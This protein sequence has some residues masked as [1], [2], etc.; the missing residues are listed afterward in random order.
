M[1]ARSE[2]LPVVSGR[3]MPAGEWQEAPPIAFLLIALL[4]TALI[5]RFGHGPVTL[6]DSLAVYWVWADQFTAELAKGNLYPRWLPASNAGLGSPVFYYYPP[7]AYYV[8][9][10]F[11]LAGLTTYASLI[12]TFW[13][14]F[15]GSGMACWAW[16]RGQ[17][18]HPLLGAAF[19]MAA[20]YHLFNYVDRGAL[21]E[22][23]AT[24]LIPV[25]AIGLRRIAGGRG[26]LVMTAMTYGAMIGTHL[27]L[28]LLAGVFLVAPYALVHR[29]R[30][31]QFA[32]AILLGTAAAAIS[33]VPSLALNSYHDVGQ[34]YR[35][36]NL[37]TGYWSLLSG[38]WS[39]PTFAMI[40]AIVGA[41]VAASLVAGARRD[42]W[43]LQAIVVAFLVTGLVP[44]VWSLP[45][46]EK[47]QFPYRALSI[48][49]FGLATALARSPAILRASA[50]PLIASAAILPG[51]YNV[52][53]DLGRLR[54]MHPDV[55]EYLPKG[56]LR[57]NQ[58][59][60]MLSDV[61]ATRIPAPRIHGMVVESR[62]Y[63]PAWSC[64]TVEPRTQLL[65]H[66]AGCNPHITSTTAEKFGAAVSLL[67]ALALSMLASGR[68]FA[69]LSKPSVRL[70]D[71]LLG[72][73]HHPEGEPAIEHCAS[74]CARGAS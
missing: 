49:E 10:F 18:Q 69:R 72:Q 43:S 39:D 50:I 20:P 30:F 61:L 14:A 60:A 53:K 57:P 15:A 59:T 47:V 56:V 1:D 11:G 42:R 32:T 27:P 28:A 70:R 34:L 55:Y 16:L 29:H 71:A 45:L 73:A 23:L 51:F 19:F 67:A 58:T 46:L 74:D 52:P 66:E 17:S 36:P 12:A 7:L 2:A 31:P 26:G 38:H 24:A 22:S 65:M 64:G 54:S 5:F 44:L 41:T 35:S 21:A 8:C 48:A 4:A 62:F 37:R 3:S 6:H 68:R 63:F 33:L 9:G 25:L 40:F 13:V